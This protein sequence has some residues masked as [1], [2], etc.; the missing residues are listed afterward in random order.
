VNLLTSIEQLPP[1]LSRRIALITDSIVEEL[2]GWE[3]LQK[4]DE[5]GF[6]VDLFSFPAGE[7]SKTRATK[8]DLEDRMLA[9]GLNRDCCVL[10]LGGGVVLDLAG[11]VAATFCRGVPLILIPTTLLAMADS[12]IGG[13]NGVNTPAGKNLIGSFL[14]PKA[15]LIDLDFLGSLSL[16]QIQDGN[17]EM[18]KHGL[19]ADADYFHALPDLSL[20]DAIVRSIGIKQAVIDQDLKETGLRRI[21][22]FGHT[23]GHAVEK[24]SDYKI[25]HGQCVAF[26]LRVE[27]QISHLLGCLDATSLEM[28][29]SAVSSLSIPFSVQEILEAMSSDKKSVDSKPRFVVLEKIGRP[30]PCDGHYCKTVDP[31]LVIDALSTTVCSS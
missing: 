3:W 19:I 5:R 13:K 27:S 16:E 29:Q 8:Q 15:V 7:F 9:A 4:L 18:I 12:C 26:G 2:Y 25:S 1:F 24:L 23:I 28:I 17:T 30:L 6:E 10:A 22:N 20:N 11:F 21:L 31:K 14:Q